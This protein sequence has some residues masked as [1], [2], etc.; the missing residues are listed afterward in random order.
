MRDAFS[1]LRSARFASTGRATHS[2]TFAMPSRHATT[3]S[4]CTQRPHENGFTLIELLVVIS[5]IALLIGILLPALG[6][7]RNS[8]RDIA[9]LSNLRQLGLA[10]TTYATDNQ[11]YNVPYRNVWSGPTIYWSARLVDDGYIGGGEAYICPT[12]EERGFDPWSPERIDDGEKGS[13]DWLE[14]PDWLLIHYAMN[15]SNVG[16]IQRRTRFDPAKYARQI[17]PGL[18]TPTPQTADFAQPS[19]MYYAMDGAT[20]SGDMSTP[21][22][23]VGGRGGG[24]TITGSSQPPDRVAGSNF[25]WDSGGMAV[26]NSGKPH[27]RHG[28]GSINI[29]YADGHSGALNVDGA[30]NA[31][32]AATYAAAYSPDNLTDARF[33]DPNAWTETGTSNT[34]DYQAP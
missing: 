15:T 22:R 13:Q 33:D 7:A 19:E 17:E 23:S 29:T 24:G 21:G 32:S 1:A 34:A 18:S 26:G 10:V 3:R 4:R 8:A 2:A 20:T 12:M 28:G 31:M 30:P 14:D 5:I 25:V 27:A 6:A 16:S 9:C 11:G